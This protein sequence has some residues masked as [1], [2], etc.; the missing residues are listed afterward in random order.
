MLNYLGKNY[1]VLLE[2]FYSELLGNGHGAL[3]TGLSM[4]I[5]LS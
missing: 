2:L 4:Y 5:Y 1:K 3:R